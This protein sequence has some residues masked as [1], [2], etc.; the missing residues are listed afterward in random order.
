MT[1]SRRLALAG[2]ATLAAAP[3]AMAQDYPSRPIEMIVAFGAG[4]G[5]DIGAR[6]VARFIEKHLG[7]GAR[8]GVVN[9][10]G[11]GGE[12]GWTAL[13]Q[14]RPDGYTIGFINAPAIV[15]MTVEK[16]TRFSIDGFDPI[17]N[18]VTDANVLF[19]HRDSQ[20]TSLADLVAFAKA[21]PGAFTIG[22]SG[23]PGNS[24]HLA[25]LVMQRRAE[26]R[27]N[28]APFGGS[29]P[30]KTALLGRHV[31][32]ATLGLSEVVQD[33]REGRIRVLGLMAEARHRWL[34]DL[35]TFRE[36]GIDVVLSSTRGF[37]GP[38]SMPAAVL[39]GFAAGFERM[40]TDAQFLAEAE[41]AGL[42]L[43]LLTGAAHRRMVDEEQK[44]IAA[45]FARRPW[46]Q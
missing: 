16:Q 4:G 18:L 10:P 25:L 43:R 28:H 44:V 39:A 7:G 3:R 26:I 42:P 29:A 36:Q 38:P 34:P 9:R 20:I 27:F 6:S 19:V 23:A 8:I 40:F 11:A 33:A 37:F 32:A 24:E 30:L 12:V 21:N 22:T 31:P 41:R 14:A 46:T 17:G 15:A 1:I 13:A 45:L 35:A 5:T 2:A